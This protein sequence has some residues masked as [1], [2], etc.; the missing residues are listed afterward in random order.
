MNLSH[1]YYGQAVGRYQ[2]L[3]DLLNMEFEDIAE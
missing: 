2:E 3:D 1:E